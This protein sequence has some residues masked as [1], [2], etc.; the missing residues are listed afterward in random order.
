MWKLKNIFMKMKEKKGITGTD[1]AVAI[2]VIV[3]TVGIVTVIYVNAINKSKD[4]IRYA[5]ATRIATNIMENIQKQPYQ[6]VLARYNANEING[7]N[8]IKVFDTKIPNGYKVKITLSAAQTPDIARDVTINVKYK[9]SMT[10]KTLTLTT[11]KEKELMD[12]T[13]PPDM[14]LIPGYKPNDTANYYYPVKKSGN[15]YYVSTASDIEWYNYENGTYAL[16]CKTN[17][18]NLTNGTEV[19]SGLYAW[20]PRF[21][22][23]DGTGVDKVQFLYGA[24]NYKITLNEYGNLFSYGVSYSGNIN[25]NSVPNK[26]DSGFNYSSFVEND[27]L[28]GVWYEIGGANSNKPGINNNSTVKQIATSLISKIPCTNATIN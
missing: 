26:Y 25:D 7:G 9:T 24:S 22:S 6:Y 28:N 10:Y 18:G 23:K 13:N 2:T 5:N 11:V 17:N 27:G 12:M 19:N 8:N 16:V 20:I 4:N 21:V 1:V 3:L 15:K 14:S